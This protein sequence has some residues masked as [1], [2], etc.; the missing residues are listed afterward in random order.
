MYSSFLKNWT[1]LFHVTDIHHSEI[2]KDVR[3][4]CQ[5]IAIKRN[6]EDALALYQPLALALTKVQSS[7]CHIADC[8]IIW[9]DL[10]EKLMPSMSL[11]QKKMFKDR[12]E[13]A[14]TP[15][16]YAAYLISPLTK[17]NDLLTQEEIDKGVK[18]FEDDFSPNF[19]AVY[20]K[21]KGDVE[22]FT[23]AIMKDDVI[24]NFTSLQWWEVFFKTNPSL[25]SE[26]DKFK[27]KRLLSAVASSSDIERIFSTFGQ[28]HSKLRNCLGVD[29][30]SKLTFLYKRLNNN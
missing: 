30:A 26:D 2:D 12:Y 29:K 4:Y 7:T 5:N 8:L 6:C 3:A 9:K 23:G 14:M 10:H 25:I 19:L 16:H 27:I 28:V 20:F 22:P 18:H 15:F 17:N 1:I 11:A 24:K 21:F 13:M